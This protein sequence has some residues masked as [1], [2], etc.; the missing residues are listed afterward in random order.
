MDEE[1]KAEIERFLKEPG[2]P[3]H[4]GCSED[5]YD[6]MADR[7]REISPLK[8]CSVKDWKWV[9]LN[10][11]EE[12]LDY[13][14]RRGTRPV[15]LY[16]DYCIEDEMRRF[17]IGSWVRTTP[18]AQ[19]I[20]PCFFITL[21]TVY[22]LVGPGQRKTGTS[23]LMADI[24]KQHYDALLDAMAGAFSALTRKRDD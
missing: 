23:L 19:F 14:K 22:I 8:R 20:E 4:L 2:E 16:A 6:E 7:A 17:S 13:I 9:D 21:S 5:E 12:E 10:V 15:V 11:S 18:L 3:C 24:D 1:R